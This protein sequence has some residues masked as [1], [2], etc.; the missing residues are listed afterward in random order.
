MAGES[1]GM[2]VLMRRRNIKMQAVFS[3]SLQ[4]DRVQQQSLWDYA[5]AG[6]DAAG[7]SE[8][9]PLPLSNGRNDTRAAFTLAEGR[10]I[11][12]WNGDARTFDA[13]SVR[14]TIS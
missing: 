3:P 11:A 14:R 13:V 9:I 12:A 2:W 1:G 10:V 7:W 6:V 5:V 8:P 4:R